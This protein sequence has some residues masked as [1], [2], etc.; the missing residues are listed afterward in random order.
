MSRAT[1]R[2]HSRAS[3][4]SRS[5]RH[6]GTR[7]ACSGRRHPC[8]LL[9]RPPSAFTV[10]MC[11]LPSSRL[12]LEREPPAVR[13]PSAN[14]AIAQG[15]GSVASSR[16]VR[17]GDP[18]FIPSPDRASRTRYAGRSAKTLTLESETDDRATGSRGSPRARTGNVGVIDEARENQSITAKRDEGNTALTPAI[19]IRS[20]GP[21]PSTRHAT[22]YWK[23]CPLR[24]R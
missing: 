3:T 21:L 9:Q 23:P 13:R 15:Y 22:R 7:P 14:T 18:H 24:H 12:R 5:I 20:G 17:V 16:S 11:Q 1:C 10:Q 19:S 6:R 8:D 2:V 4:R